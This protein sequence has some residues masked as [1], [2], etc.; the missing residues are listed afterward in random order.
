M[1]SLLGFGSSCLFK[2]HPTHS[3]DSD[4][5]NQGILLEARLSHPLQLSNSEKQD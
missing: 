2:P 1:S 4:A 5:S 3:A